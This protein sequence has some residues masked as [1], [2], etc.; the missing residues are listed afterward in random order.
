MSA[1][2]KRLFRGQ[3]KLTPEIYKLYKDRVELDFIIKSLREIPIDKLK[4][5]TGFEATDPYDGKVPDS[6]ADSQYR[7]SLM[8]LGVIEFRMEILI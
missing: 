8:R 3:Q 5:L 1:S 7:D 6:M 2:E 4:K